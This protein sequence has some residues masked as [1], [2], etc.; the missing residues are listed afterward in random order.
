M[1]NVRL[2]KGVYIMQNTTVGEGGGCNGRWARKMKN[3]D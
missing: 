1:I 2:L 3:E